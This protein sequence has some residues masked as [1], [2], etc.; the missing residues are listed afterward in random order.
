MILALAIGTALLVLSHERRYP[1]PASDLHCVGI[2][3]ALAAI[4]SAIGSAV[5]TAAGP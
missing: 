2:L 3:T 5:G 4:A 1:G